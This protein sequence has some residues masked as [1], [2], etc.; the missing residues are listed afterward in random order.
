MTL[1]LKYITLAVMG[2]VAFIIWSVMAFY[3]ASLRSDYLKFIVSVV[4]GTGGLALRDMPNQPIQPVAQPVV[5]PKDITNEGNS[6]IS[7]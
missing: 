3:D 1:N 4:L 2:G 7:I 5:Q 6:T